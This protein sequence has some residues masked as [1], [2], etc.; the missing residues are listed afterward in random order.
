MAIVLVAGGVHLSAETIRTEQTSLPL[1][2]A[3]FNNLAFDPATNTFMAAGTGSFQSPLAAGSQRAMSFKKEGHS[4]ESD[5]YARIDGTSVFLFEAPGPPFLAHFYHLLEHLVGLWSFDLHRRSE[6]VTR[7]VLAGDGR[8]DLANWRGPNGINE[9][10]LK[11]LFPNAQIQTWQ[12]FHAEALQQNRPLLFQRLVTSD[13]AQTLDRPICQRINKMLAEVAA[14]ISPRSISQLAT[15]LHSYA[16]TEPKLHDKLR[17]TYTK[18][19]PPRTLSPE[20]ESQLLDRLKAIPGVELQ[21]VDFAKISFEE[22]IRCIAQTDL[23]L[24]VHGNGLSHAL[25]L[26]DQA[27]VI[28]ILP[29]DSMILDY[30]LFS[31][32]RG[33]R[34]YAISP[35][36]GVVDRETAYRGCHGNLNCP[37]DSLNLDPLI[38]IV[39]QLAD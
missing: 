5:Q 34:Y 33:L 8:L 15:R 32:A 12:E 17:V 11:A 7:I 23:L 29:P 31:E 2:F 3:S 22:Q 39:K 14:Q 38:E 9:H 6:T 24:G 27:A 20:L 37:I 19:G 4:L 25:F 1:P 28:E 26:P 36:Y 10:L 16:K 18:R 30:R 21:A 13:R 35:T